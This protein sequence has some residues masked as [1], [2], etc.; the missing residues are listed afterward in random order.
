MIRLA[1]RNDARGLLSSQESRVSNG[2]DTTS[3][4]TTLTTDRKRHDRM[5]L[6]GC[7]FLLGVCVA[8]DA[9]S[10]LVVFTSDLLLVNGSAKGVSWHRVY[11]GSYRL[12]F[13]VG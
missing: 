8:A 10:A 12:R 2:A 6:G 11:S 4:I 3:Q 7:V 13:A 1:I 9:D 5:G